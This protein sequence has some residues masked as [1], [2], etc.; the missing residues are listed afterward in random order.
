MQQMLCPLPCGSRWPLTFAAVCRGHWGVRHLP[1]AALTRSS[2]HLSSPSNA[3]ISHIETEPQP[4]PPSPARDWPLIK[5]GVGD[6][7]DCTVRRLVQGVSQVELLWVGS[8]NFFKLLSQQ[9]IL[10]SL[11]KKQLELCPSRGA[12][13]SEGQ[14]I[15]APAA[16]FQLEC[17]Q[18]ILGSD[19]G[20]L[21]HDQ[22]PLGGTDGGC[23]PSGWEAV[24]EHWVPAPTATAALSTRPAKPT[25][26]G[27]PAGERRWPHVTPYTPPPALE[28]HRAGRGR[29]LCWGE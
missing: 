11:E 19:S 15:P 2:P 9:D 6:N 24:A 7:G 23:R 25:G 27:S 1:S 22:P 21:P 26:P 12:A 3:C 16:S 29:S 8:G 28:S 20:R 14:H 18:Q 4:Q 5:S 17:A 10:L 13:C